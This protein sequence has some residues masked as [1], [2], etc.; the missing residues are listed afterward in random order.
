MKRLSHEDWT[1]MNAMTLEI[2]RS[3]TEEGLLDLVRRLVCE[4]CGPECEV[5]ASSPDAAPQP[6]HLPLGPWTLRQT[7]DLCERSRVFLEILA[8]HFVDAWERMQSRLPKL[9]APLSKRQRE[10]LPLLLNGDSNAEIAF[11]LGISARTTEKH[12]AAIIRL[13]GVTSRTQFLAIAN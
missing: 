13:H 6:Q 2:H 8:P 5:L 10:V 7:P 11:K 1:R 9:S 3:S 4:I 12:V